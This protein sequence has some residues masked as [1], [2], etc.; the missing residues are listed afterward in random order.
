MAAVSGISGHC[1]ERPVVY[2]LSSNCGQWYVPSNGVTLPSRGNF[3]HSAFEEI[4]NSTIGIFI[5]NYKFQ[6]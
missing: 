3:A 4:A 1:I 6:Q 2:V 5:F